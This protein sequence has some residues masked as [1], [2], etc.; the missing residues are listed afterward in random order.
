MLVGVLFFIIMVFILMVWFIKGW[1]LEEFKNFIN[2]FF[3]K[4]YGVS[5]D[6]VF[7]FRYVFLIVSVV[8]LGGLVVVYKKFN[9]EFIF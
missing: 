6:F 3:M 2:V 1:I 9:W 7:K 8:G 4:I 5:L